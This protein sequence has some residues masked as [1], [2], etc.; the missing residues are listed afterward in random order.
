M[1]VVGAAPAEAATGLACPGGAYNLCIPAQ[2]ANEGV[3][4]NPGSTVVAGYDFKV[5][6]SDTTM[7]QITGAYEQLTISCAN[8]A[9]PTVSSIMVPMPDVTYTAPFPQSQGWVPT[10]NQSNHASYEGSFVLGDYCNGG[11]IRVGQP[12]QMLFAAQVQWNGTSSLSFRSHYNDGS[13]S[14]SGSWSATIGI[15]P[16]P[17]PTASI[18]LTKTVCALV[19]GNDCTSPGGGPFSSS[20]TVP[21]GTS[22]VFQF[23][24]T[25]T[26]GVTL[27]NLTTNDA[28]LP[29]CGGPVPTST[30]AAGAST[31]YFCSDSVPP[32]TQSFTNT[33]SATGTPPSG[34]AVTS[35]TSSAT[36][37]V[38]G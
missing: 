15:K 34:P 30:L 18:K 27:T 37:T 12:G 3:V 5:P 11:T 22:V 31:S 2:G 20:V 6:G 23:A 10:G 21:S 33:A 36:V 26:G 14:K 1:P 32:V 19:N 24:I 4:G 16:P 38:S 9:T 29:Q 28:T 13:Y 35:P 7:V 17:P 8:H 25:N